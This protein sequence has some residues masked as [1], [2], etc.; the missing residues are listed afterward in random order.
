MFKTPTFFHQVMG[1]IA[2]INLIKDKITNIM[3]KKERSNMKSINYVIVWIGRLE[4]P[5]YGLAYHTMLP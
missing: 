4:L 1:V 5:L 2:I 3:K